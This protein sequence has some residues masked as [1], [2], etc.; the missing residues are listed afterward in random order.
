MR[1]KET[2]SDQISAIFEERKKDDIWS[3]FRYLHT[4]GSPYKLGFR[5]WVLIEAE[6]TV[7]GCVRY[8]RL[9][10]P[11]SKWLWLK[12]MCRQSCDLWIWFETKEICVW[13]WCF[14][15]DIKKINWF[16]TLIMDVLSVVS[17]ALWWKRKCSVILSVSCT[18]TTTTTNLNTICV[19]GEI[20][21]CF[22]C[23][24]VFRITGG[25]DK[26]GFP[27]K[28]GVLTNGRVRLLLSKGH[29]CYRPRRTGERRR[30]SVH[31][32]IVD[33]NLSVLSLIII[34]KGKIPKFGGPPPPP[35]PQV[36]SFYILD[37]EYGLNVV[38]I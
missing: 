4:V 30:K 29:S 37:H 28:Q 18:P 21:K 1:R 8:F 33:A 5:T 10:L 14:V 17:H 36:F 22:K 35:P 38:R 12:K 16:V 32:C 7:K 23:V 24:F 15:L 19:Q 27:M 13:E 20:N 26:Q 3:N 31:G 25:N 11:L 9:H 6:S 2:T 34:K